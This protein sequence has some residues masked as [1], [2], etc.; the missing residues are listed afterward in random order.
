M[1]KSSHFRWFIIVLLFFITIVNYIDRAAIAFAIEEIAKDN[2]Y[3]TCNSPIFKWHIA[4]WHLSCMNWKG[5]ILGAFG[6]G[7]A[8]TTF[9]GGIWVDKLKPKKVFIGKSVKNEMTKFSGGYG[10]YFDGNSILLNISK[11]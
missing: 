9:F 10:K 4:G 7:Y 11:T 5:Y 2:S 6:L 1:A 3:Q 8:I